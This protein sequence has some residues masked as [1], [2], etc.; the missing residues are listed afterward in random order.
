MLLTFEFC[1]TMRTCCGYSC[2]SGSLG[3]P[4]MKGEKGRPGAKGERGE[5]G[6]PGPSQT[7]LLKGDKGE[8]GLKGKEL[9]LFKVGRF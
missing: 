9:F 7:T 5:K 1:C 8:P 3:I 2:L 6:K 4:G